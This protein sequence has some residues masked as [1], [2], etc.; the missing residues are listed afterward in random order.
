[1]SHPSP[2][3]VPP[4]PRPAAATRVAV[5][6]LSN[7]ARFGVSMAVWFFLTPAMVHGLGE[8]E[9]GLWSLVYSVVGFFSLLD[10]GMGTGVVKC[11]AEATG[12]GDAGRRNRMLSTYAAAYG[13][14]A[15]AAALILGVLSLVFN[16]VFS[17]PAEAHGRA[18][19]AL[20]LI[21]LRAVVL[22]FP[23]SLF[24]GILYGQQRLVLLNAL[25]ALSLVA[26]GVGGLLAL[27]YGAGVVALAAIGLASM[28]LE[29][30]LYAVFAWRRTPGL[31]LS[32]RLVDTSLLREAVSLSVSQLL[33]AVSGLAMLRT[34]PVVIQLAIGLSAVGVYAV[35]LKAAENGFMLVKQFVNALSPLIAQLHGGGRS[36]RL[37]EVLVSG[38]R[39]ACVPAV[40]LA[41]G[42]YVLGGRAL[43]LWVGPGFEGAGPV[44]SVL[45]TAMALAVPQMM[46]FSLLTYTDRHRLPARA[47]VAAAVLNLA[48]T[49]LLVRPLGLLGVALG[50][51]LAT[52]IVDVFWV[53]GSGCRELGVP[54]AGYLRE[55]ILPALVPGALQWAITAALVALRP[56]ASLL[57]VVGYGLPGVAAY[58]ALFWRVGLGDEERRW[59]LAR[60]TRRRP[61]PLPLSQEQPA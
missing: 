11:V 17:I 53:L 60:L 56:P 32:P 1:V 30:A 4:Q 37:R 59:L 34:D 9:Y 46:V 7:Y 41:V 21:G 28:L 13:G 45:V 3:A 50:T 22:A 15:L 43:V 16:R 24:R 51:L 14:V 49:L 40:L 10:L 25:Q 36:E 55:G 35:A 31:A 8:Q 44:M 58:L 39:F 54:Y 26:Y 33:I 47:S 48:L 2:A 52:L 20:W 42:C 18:L 27:R 38:T 29:H 19:A 61:S 23:L 57:E 5:N 12:N 6:T